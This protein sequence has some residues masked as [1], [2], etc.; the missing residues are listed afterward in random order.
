M[1]AIS[2]PCKPSSPR[3][4]QDK[5]VSEIKKLK[6]TSSYKK[7]KIRVKIE[8][9]IKSVV[10]LPSI[11]NRRY[12]EELPFLCFVFLRETAK[13][14]FEMCDIFHSFIHQN[15]T[16]MNYEVRLQNPKICIYVSSGANHHR[17]AKF[18]CCQNENFSRL[19]RCLERN[20]QN[21]N[22]QC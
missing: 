20:N 7:Y 17:T 8:N 12:R 16:N 1:T 19:V 4:L 15:T 6:Y 2:L 3:S 18:G 21:R 14:S 9:K 13:S 11:S 5:T 10:Y 22:P